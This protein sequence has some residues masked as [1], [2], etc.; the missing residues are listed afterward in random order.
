MIDFGRTC[1]RCGTLY[2]GIH[3]CWTPTLVLCPRCSWYYPVG[4]IHLCNSWNLNH[5]H[6]WVYVSNPLDSSERWSVCRTCTTATRL[7]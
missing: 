4:N 7:P 2:Y 6:D 5:Q 1:E 3:T